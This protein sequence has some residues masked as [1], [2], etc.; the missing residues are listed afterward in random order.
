MGH[1]RLQSISLSSLYMHANLTQ[2]L[3]ITER[4]DELPLHEAPLDRLYQ[5][6]SVVSSY[7]RNS[8]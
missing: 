2:V 4:Y 3:S 6:V 1:V 5:K 7:D 8:R